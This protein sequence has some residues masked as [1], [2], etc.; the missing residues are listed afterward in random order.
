MYGYGPPRLAPNSSAYSTPRS[1]GTT[2]LG[3]INDGDHHTDDDLPYQNPAVE[4]C[5]S[6]P[7]RSE[8]DFRLMSILEIHTEAHVK[9]SPEKQRQLEKR[10]LILR[11]GKTTTRGP[12]GREVEINSAPRQASFCR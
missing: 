4:D 12:K 9:A 10:T 1:N 7:Y 11:K 8:R 3:Q 5:L 2:Q 6:H